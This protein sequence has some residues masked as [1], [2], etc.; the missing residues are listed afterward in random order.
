MS[1]EHHEEIN[2]WDWLVLV[3][4]VFSVVIVIIETFIT[5]PPESLRALM[6][7]DYAA[8][9]IFLI[10][11]LVRWRRAQWKAHYWRWG[12]LDVLASIPLDPAFRFFQAIRV[13]RLIRLF[14]AFR[15]IHAITNGSFLSEGLLAI[16]G[17]AVVVILFCTNLVLDCE[18]NAVDSR[19]H[20]VSDALWWCFS[21]ISTVGYGDL[22][23]VTHEGRF[24]GAILMILGITLFGSMS[25]LIMSKLIRPQE[26]KD[27]AAYRDEIKLLH[28]DIRELRSELKRGSEP[29]S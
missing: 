3:T 15:R 6:W 21:T 7:V 9:G 4:A 5:L 8:C 11:V 28:D 10:D 24:I 26:L 29:K 12:W 19:I 2:Q 17:V 13:Y 25:A 14:R 20:N 22:Y 16:P 23:P 18:R 1:K 27:H